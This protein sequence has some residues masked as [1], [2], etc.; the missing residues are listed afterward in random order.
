MS[1]GPR[2][3]SPLCAWDWRYEALARARVKIADWMHDVIYR[4]IQMRLLRKNS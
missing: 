3:R 1:R 4:L 2:W